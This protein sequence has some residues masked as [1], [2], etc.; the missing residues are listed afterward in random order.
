MFK[1]WNRFF[2]IC[3]KTPKTVLRYIYTKV[4][5]WPIRTLYLAGPALYGYGFWEG[6]THEDICASLT[7]I[8]AQHWCENQDVCDALIDHKVAALRLLIEWVLL[9]YFLYQTINALCMRRMIVRPVISE[10]RTLLEQ[11]QRD[12]QRRQIAAPLSDTE[13]I[14][15]PSHKSSVEI[16]RE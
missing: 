7:N 5:T 12:T 1:S 13:D 10:L 3:L 14:A 2:S 11:A 9:V 4:W 15:T 16:L 6:K 8:P